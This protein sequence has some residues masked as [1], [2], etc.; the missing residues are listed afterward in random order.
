MPSRSD[1]TRGR[2]CQTAQNFS[3]TP[4]LRDAGA[5]RVG[6]FRIEDFAERADAR[7]IKVIDKAIEKMPGAG[8]IVGMNFQ[9]GVD[10]RTDEP[11]PH[12]ALMICRITRAQVAK[13]ARF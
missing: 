12:G 4:G 10:E 11:G 7:V 2:L 3:N 8:T 13:V 1:G 6:L 5:R 9:P